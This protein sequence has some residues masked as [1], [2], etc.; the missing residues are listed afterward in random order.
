MPSYRSL[1]SSLHGPDAGAA[2]RCQALLDVKTMP[3]GS[4]GRREELAC[5]LAALKGKPSPPRWA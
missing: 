2:A 1:L 3:R 5:R 4:L